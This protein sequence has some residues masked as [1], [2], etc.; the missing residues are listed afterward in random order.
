ME[1]EMR[2]RKAFEVVDPSCPQAGRD[3]K[4]PIN[5]SGS[6]RAFQ[7]WAGHLGVTFEEVLESIPF[8]TGTGA[9]VYRWVENG[10][11]MVRIEAVGYRRGP[12]GDY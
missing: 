4:S 1:K 9:W 5:T 6:L 8:M 12:A 3:W 11:E 7:A 10:E 2:L